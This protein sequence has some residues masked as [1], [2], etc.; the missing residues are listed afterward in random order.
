MIY[1]VNQ[2]ISDLTCCLLALDMN[3][4]TQEVKNERF[5]ILTRQNNA[6]FQHTLPFNKATNRQTDIKH[7]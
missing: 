7:E 3:Q 5:L 2:K 4:N 6:N 1:D